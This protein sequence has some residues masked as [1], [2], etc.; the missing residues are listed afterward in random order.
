MQELN[1]EMMLSIAVIVLTIIAIAVFIVYGAGIPFY[2]LF[3]IVVVVMFYTWQKI[4]AE[5][6]AKKTAMPAAKPKARGRKR[7]A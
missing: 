2:A 5:P 3:V 4:S 1:T 7:R 6:T